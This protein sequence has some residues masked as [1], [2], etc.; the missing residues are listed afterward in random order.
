M[1]ELKCYINLQYFVGMLK[2]VILVKQPLMMVTNFKKE[3]T[4]CVPTT[5]K[6]T[7]QHGK[8]LGKETWKVQ[9]QI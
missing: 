6:H 7:L 5:V 8:C 2:T 3:T 9:Y 4:G 1:V